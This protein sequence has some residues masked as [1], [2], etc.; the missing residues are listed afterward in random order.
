MR[1]GASREFTTRRRT[2]STA[3]VFVASL[4]LPSRM[5]FDDAGNLFVDAGFPT[6]DT[7]LKF[8]PDGTGR[9]SSPVSSIRTRSPSSRTCK[10]FVTSARTDRCKLATMPSSAASSLVGML[11]RAMALLSAPLALR[12]PAT[13]SRIRSTIPPSNCTNLSPPDPR[14]AHLRQ[15]SGWVLYCGCSWRAKR[16]WRRGGGDLQHR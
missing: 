8:A 14:E 6:V 5:A 3:E 16:D 2:R 1:T 13:E 9:R 15:P 10:S 11:S 4:P 7:I 12:W